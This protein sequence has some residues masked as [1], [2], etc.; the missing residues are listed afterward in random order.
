MTWQADK[1]RVQFTR[2]MEDKR[3]WDSK[4]KNSVMLK[5]LVRDILIV[6]YL[7]HVFSS[8]FFTCKF[9]YTIIIDNYMS[10]I[11]KIIDRQHVICSYS[12]FR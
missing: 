12:S 9:F 6:F 7:A 10:N 1:I 5:I 3:E 4:L 8:V 11:I 2:L